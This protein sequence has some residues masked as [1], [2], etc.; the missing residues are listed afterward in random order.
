VES[1]YER[2]EEFLP[3]RWGENPELVLNKA[4]FVPFSSGKLLVFVRPVKD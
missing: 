3:E 2:A 1:C 4:V